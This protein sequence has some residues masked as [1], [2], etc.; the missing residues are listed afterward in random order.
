MLHSYIPTL[1]APTAESP[2]WYKSYHS[3]FYMS[4]LVN[5]VLL[6]Y[7]TSFIEIVQ[8][9]GMLESLHEE[10]LEEKI[11]TPS[12]LNQG[13]YTI[14][15][16]KLYS[17]DIKNFINEIIDNFK[18]QAEKINHMLICS[19]V[20]TGGYLERNIEINLDEISKTADTEDWYD[21]VKGFLNVWEFMF[22]FSITESTLKDILSKPKAYTSNLIKELNEQH[23]EIAKTMAED[24]KIDINLSDSIW[25]LFASIRNTYSHTHGMI[26]TKNKT[27][28]TR[29]S[30]IFKKHFRE[31]FHT[32]N[33]PSSL[34]LSSVMIDTDQLFDGKKI[35]LGKFF[36]ISD[37]E[38]NIFRNFVSE[39]INTASK[40]KN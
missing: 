28:L 9:N 4:Q 22:L 26:A 10:L 24:H 5:N 16:E 23:P 38:L 25:R 18:K 39:Y 11:I 3:S 19:G 37:L 20:N 13:H 6:S 21:I 27:E 15:H 12:E 14:N 7:L 33:D 40:L 17:K 36:F 1:E 2:D 34:I 29:D 8:K 35:K 32:P 31:A 30:E